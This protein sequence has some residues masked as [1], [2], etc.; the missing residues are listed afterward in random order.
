[1]QRIAPQWNNPLH[2]LATIE[3]H[4]HA[5]TLCTTL[6]LTLMLLLLLAAAL[7]APRRARLDAAMF[8][9]R[10]ATAASEMVLR[11]NWLLLVVDYAQGALSRPRSNCASW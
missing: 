1:M 7:R 6:C 9:S 2:H 3:L 11:R 8:A 4:E 10:I 5:R